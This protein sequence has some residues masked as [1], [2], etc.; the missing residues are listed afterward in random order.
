MNGTI[1][2]A[3]EGVLQTH[4]NQPILTGFLLIGSLAQSNRV[5]LFT[6]GSKDRVE[7]QMRTEKLQDKIA[8][9]VDE[10]LDLPPLPLWQRQLEVLRTRHPV[11]M[12]ITAEPQLA[13]WVVEKGMTSLFFAHPGFS[14]PAQRPVQGNRNWENLM[15]ELEART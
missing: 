12:V 1:A 11:T 8:E 10:S 9:I 7:H 13:Q 4:K 6:S 2:V 3:Y 5:V 15:E 14:R